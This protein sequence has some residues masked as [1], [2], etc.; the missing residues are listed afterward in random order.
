MFGYDF[1]KIFVF[2][3]RW[4]KKKLGVKMVEWFFNKLIFVIKKGLNDY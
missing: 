3:G 2:L 4:F 1:V